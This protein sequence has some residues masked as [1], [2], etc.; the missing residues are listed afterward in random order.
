MGGIL[1]AVH[2]GIGP[3]AALDIGLRTKNFTDG[4]KQCTLK[5]DGIVL[6]LPAAVTAAVKFEDQLESFWMGAHS[7]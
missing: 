5:R 3:A 7:Q 4:L 2:T 6:F 1:Q